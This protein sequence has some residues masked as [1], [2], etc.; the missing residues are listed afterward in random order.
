ME[1][2]KAREKPFVL[3]TKE[4][5][6]AIV[7][8]RKG[9]AVDPKDSKKG[10]WE[11][12]VF[13]WWVDKVIPKV[14]SMKRWALRHKTQGRISEQPL[15]SSYGITAKTCPPSDEA[16]AMITYEN[17]EKRWLFQVCTGPNLEALV[18]I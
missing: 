1:V 6:Y 12:K 18:I 2:R 10:E 14:A 9:M 7:V 3:P 15:D 17:G 11:R 4:Q 13:V 5:L 16:F 8:E